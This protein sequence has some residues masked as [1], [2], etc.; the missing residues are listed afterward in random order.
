M[1]PLP[2]SALPPVA[3]DEPVTTRL[4]QALWRVELLGGLALSDGDQ[5]LARLP[6]RA[7]TCL[8]ARLALA[9][10]R[11]HGREELIELL[12]PGVALDVGRNRLRQALSTL[13]SILEPASRVPA[14][15]VLQADRAQVRVVSGTLA[16]DVIDFERAVRAGDAGAAHALYRG[17]LLPGFYDEWIDD[18]RLRLAGLLDRL[19]LNGPAPQALDARDPIEVPARPRASAAR[20]SLP[21]YLTRMFGADEQGAQLRSLVLAQRLVTLVGPGGAGKSRLAVEVSHSL[22]EHAAWPLP[23]SQP[24]EPFDLIAFIPL[25]ACTTPAQALDA[26]T[27]TLQIAPG[28]DAPLD[29][30]IAALAGRRTLLVL[31]NFEQLVRSGGDVVARLLSAV[32]HLH[33]IV[34]SRRALGIDGEHEFAVRTLPLPE[35]GDDVE[36]A[37]A[38][39]A[40][41]LFT[42]RAR[43]VRADFHLG[44]RNVA[45]V[46]DIVRALE[47]MPLAL[48]LAASRVRSISPADMR[49][50]LQGTGTPRLDLLQRSVARG[51][52]DQRHASMQRV[53]A[54]SLDQ[55]DADQ[56]RLL[57][58][59]TVFAGPFSAA[60]AMALTSTE[61]I[62]TQLLLDDLV[63]HC[64]V[65]RHA[66]SDD[67]R[68]GLYQ[69]IREVVASRQDAAAARHWRQRLRV[70]AVQWARDLPPTPPLPAVRAEMPNL[71]AALASAVDD[72]AHGDA[73]ALLLAL[74]RCVEEVELPAEGLVH[75]QA[76]IEGCEDPVLKARGHSQ[77]GP[78]LFTAGQ[79]AAALR[80]AELG[81][82]CPA[83]DGE[84]RAQAL[85]ALARVRWRSRRLATEVEPLLDEADG[86]AERGA[87]VDLRA[88]LLA[89]RAFVTIAH[90]R[91]QVAGERLHVQALALWQQTGNQHAINSGR[92]NLAVCAQNANRHRDAVDQLQPII[93]S[94]FDHQD[95]RRLNQSLNVRGNGYSGLRQWSLAVADYQQCIRVAWKSMASFDLAFGLW[96][97]SRALAHLRQPEAAVRLVAFAALFWCTRFGEL[98][99]EDR[100]YIRL[101]RRLVARRLDPQR[102]DGLT[103]DGE[104]LSLSQAVALA[105][106]ARA[107]A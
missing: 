52:A 75:A 80:H 70:W 20:V 81:V 56:V 39:P 34:T 77:L 44:S 57:A 107:E 69:P 96:N 71:L 58:A 68:F 40:V 88:N 101:V 46:V 31:D 53:I 11:A 106:A 12:W 48:E 87:D 105:L 83:I 10:A 21:H 84:Q 28:A 47:G 23:A 38:N 67:D 78:M 65:H 41:A 8:L 6:S 64:L 74:R 99:A 18:E 25:A 5:R 94:A 55:L 51:A 33:V 59:L 54:W 30:L 66:G 45:A 102:I 50:R 26:L 19:P 13:K 60:A 86:L 22:R 61:S 43:A 93:L 79:A 24:F 32:P 15:A 29:A 27:T 2:T 104:Q 90:H 49:L 42:E 76:A 17:E 1:N 62:D 35:P 37:A 82:A 85:Y 92:Y 91:D 98:S 63:A 95:W 7:I 103:R 4:A 89:T 73:I 16:C 14:Q 9:P 36:C 3:R 72:S 100:H 97:L